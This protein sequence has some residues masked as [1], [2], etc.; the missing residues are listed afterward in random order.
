MRT[1]H[2][3]PT[4]RDRGWAAR[5]GRLGPVLIAAPVV[6]AIAVVSFIV[7]DAGEAS[8]PEAAA[9]GS[10]AAAT[11]SA[12]PPAASPAA[13]P[14]AVPAK[15]GWVAVDPDE[16]K[17][18]TAAFFARTPRKVT[19]KPVQVPEFHATCTVSHHGD[20]DPIVFPGLPGASH[21]HTFWGNKSTDSRTTAVSLRAGATSCNPQQ[22]RSGYWIP[23]LYQNGR[24]I[25]PDE[26][27][28]YYGS[29]L[30]DP[31]KTQPFPYGLRMIEG[32]A[33]K[34]S[35]P[36]GNR[37]WCAGIG[38]EVGRSKD[39]VF[40]VCASTAHIVRQI[41]FPDCWDG[42]HL[43]SPDHKAHMSG[44]LHTGVCPRSHPIPIPSVSFVISYKDLSAK[45]DGITLS[46]GNSFSM[47]AD[48]FNGWDPEALAA[49]VRNC[50]NQGVKCNAAGGF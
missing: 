15:P 13:K 41:T 5:L 42:K 23:T 40:P 50:L 16:Q 43:D 22:D 21:N 46:S 14:S 20:D 37:F 12:A 7:T 9:T 17:A 38:G 35:D 1:E 39:G 29:R 31:A 49:R 30:K 44:A 10:A 24:V 47:H 25:D 45:T 11:P 33:K 18:A 28:V 3:A 6:L 2:S 4:P 8:T 26:I 34:K 48:F 19:G 32:D 36:N 27:T